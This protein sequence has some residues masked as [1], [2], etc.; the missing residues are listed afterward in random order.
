MKTGLAI[1]LLA[2]FC[3]AQQQ[4]QPK[5]DATPPPK[6]PVTVPAG[7]RTLLVLLSPLSTKSA[8]V[9][10]GVYLQTA[11]PITADNRTVIPPGA[12][13]DG[14]IEHAVRPGRIKGRAELQIHFTKVTFPSGYSE[15]LPA[16]LAGAP[17]E[18]NAKITGEGTIQENGQKGRDIAAIAGTTATGAVIGGLADDGA[19]GAGIGAG[20]GAAVALATVLLTR[21]D[22]LR[23]NA[24]DP[25]EM[26]LDRPMVLQHT[27]SQSTGF[28]TVPRPVR[29]EHHDED[30]RRQTYPVGYPGPVYP[31]VIWTP[32]WPK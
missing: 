26:V 28:E 23:L 31:P 16:S 9:G 11:V 6:T 32:R 29:R 4:P 7:T 18:E 13:I 27:E 20:V 30:D 17:A 24:G 3:T 8:Q 14:V 12:Y 5:P 22:E 1:L 19:R 21:G 2:G 25:I 15:S 10:H